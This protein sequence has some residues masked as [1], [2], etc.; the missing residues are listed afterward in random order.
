MGVG[1]RFV[2]LTLGKDM[3]VSDTAVVA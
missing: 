1:R 2:Q 3:V